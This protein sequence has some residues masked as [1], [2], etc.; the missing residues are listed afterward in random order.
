MR[1]AIIDGAR[2]LT[3]PRGRAA[4]RL[5]WKLCLLGLASA[6]PAAGP[7]RA[8]LVLSF[9]QSSYLVDASQEFD[10]SVYLTESGTNILATDGL[11][12]AG[13]VVSFNLPATAS[14]PAQATLITPNAGVSDTDD[15]VSTS[16]T[17]ATSSQA[18]TAQLLFSIFLSDNLF[19]PSGSSSILIGTFRFAAGAVPG[20][21]TNLSVAIAGG[22]PQFF[23]GTGQE[24]DGQITTT[25][26]SI[27][28]RGSTAVPE[29]HSLL[30]LASGLVPAA[31][32]MRRNARLGRRREG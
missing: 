6:W 13:V 28:V 31:G 26:A 8:D 29:P 2:G 9:D 25:T 7:A 5:L 32:L 22:G 20:E 11:A 23:S 16:I 21:T 30:L 19:P 10:V 4:S 1:N 14:D 15:L 3:P 24:L 18:G 12:S 27:T 17:P